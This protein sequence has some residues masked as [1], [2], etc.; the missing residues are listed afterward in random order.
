MTIEYLMSGCHCSR[1][2]GYVCEQ[3]KDPFLYEIY[4]LALLEKGNVY[5]D[6]WQNGMRLLAVSG[7][8]SGDFGD[9]ALPR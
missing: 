5:S 4:S 2:L 1:T 3:N 8:W 6:D 7:N 9:W